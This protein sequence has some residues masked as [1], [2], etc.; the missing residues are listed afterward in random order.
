[1]TLLH[2]CYSGAAAGHE[3]LLGSSWESSTHPGGEDIFVQNSRPELQNGR[4]GVKSSKIRARA[5]GEPDPLSVNEA[6][7]STFTSKFRGN[8]EILP[9]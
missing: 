7:F 3:K 5:E 4:G 6:L 9:L 2:V 1:M 8:P